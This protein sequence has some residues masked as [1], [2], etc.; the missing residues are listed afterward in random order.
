MHFVDDDDIPFGISDLR[1][2]LRVAGEPTDVGDHALLVLERVARGVADFDR[3][4][5]FFVE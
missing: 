5:A 2:A 3:L 4:A 1:S